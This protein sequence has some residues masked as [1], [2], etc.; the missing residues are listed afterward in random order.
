[1]KLGIATG[2]PVRPTESIASSSWGALEQLV[3]LLGCQISAKASGF[4]LL[5]NVTQ[6]EPKTAGLIIALFVA[7]NQRIKE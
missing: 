3:Y 2:L 1:M 6:E 7:A 4:S 5:I